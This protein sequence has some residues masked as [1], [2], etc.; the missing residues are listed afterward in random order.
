MP[1]FMTKMAEKPHPL[2]PHIAIYPIKG[3]IPPCH[4]PTET[5]RLFIQR[6]AKQLPLLRNVFE[7][8]SCGPKLMA[9]R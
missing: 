5:G 6:P 7:L 8:S 9:N 1:Y 3:S 2:R 4:F